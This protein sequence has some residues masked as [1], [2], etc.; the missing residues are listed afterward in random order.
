[1]IAILLL[2]GG[3]A[4]AQDLE[5]TLLTQVWVTAFDQDVDAQADPA[6]Y[7]DPEDD[8]GFKLRRARA[9]FAGQDGDF[10]YGLVLGMSSGADGLTQSDGTVGIVDA[11]AGW[12]VH[13]HF[14]L[15]A[16]VQK[17][18]FG[19]EQM[20]SSGELVF[21]E[22]AVTSNHIAPG[23]ELGVLA[24]SGAQGAD[25]QIGLFNGNGSILGDDN[26]G[27]MV[28][29]RA[30]YTLG[31]GPSD[32]TYGVVESVVVSLGTNLFYD[33]GTATDTLAYGADLLLRWSGLAVLA[34][35]HL[36]SIS[37]QDSTLDVPEVFSTT[38]RQGALLQAGWTLGQFEP[39]VRAEIYDDDKSATDNGDILKV[40]AGVT[41][42]FNDDRVRAGMA[43]VHRRELGGQSLSNDSA[44]LFFQMRH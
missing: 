28:A 22:R 29:A 6:G 10:S 16:G 20:L 34:E 26:D 8:R 13:R 42:H 39:A 32:S 44:R 36:A 1:M 15:T 2:L 27:M 30:G 11:Y 33:Q 18:P 9:G 4:Q 14:Q 5:P 25:I 21:Q 38:D 7:G 19:R 31:D 40:I 43:Y 12:Q 17:V 41:A 35:V 3:E 24:S 37:P 23:R